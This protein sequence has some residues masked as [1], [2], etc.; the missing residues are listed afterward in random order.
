MSIELDKIRR[1][2]L[3]GGL[4]RKDL[5]D[6]PLQ[7]F[8]TWQQQI[9]TLGT[10]DPTAMVVATVDAEGQPSQRIVLLKQ[11]DA[12]GFVF[13][14]NYGSR[15]AQ[16]IAGN[17]RVSLLFPWHAVERQVK[18]CGRAEKLGMAESL[19][20]FASRPRDSQ[21]AAW[22][23]QQ[24]SPITGRGFLMNQ[25]AHMKEKFAHGEVPLPDFWGGIRVVPHEIE[26][27]QGGAARLH[28]RFRYRRQPDRRW[29]I[30]R[31]AP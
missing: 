27:W 10:L 11:L 15:K 25:L 22:A 16:E 17:P 3:A 5:P 20:Y 13:F 18:V 6:D 7:L 23:S 30:E 26:F 19:R 12:Q 4:R 14:T 21:L 1:E 24:S 28:D 29:D 31:L 9:I 2:Y 8:E